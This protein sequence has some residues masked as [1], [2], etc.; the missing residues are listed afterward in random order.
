MVENKQMFVIGIILILATAAIFLFV[1]NDVG[2]SPMV[3]G[4]IGITMI[5]A[6]NYKPLQKVT[7]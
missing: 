3:L 6:S 1:E 7:N 5:G 2:I 4:I